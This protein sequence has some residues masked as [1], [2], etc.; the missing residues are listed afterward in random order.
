MFQCKQ[1]TVADNR[2]AMKI[3]TDGMLL[4]AWA[5]VH[6]NETTILDIGTGSGIIALMMAQRSIAE[7]IDGLEIDPDAYE[8][9]VE[10]F[11]N[12]KWNDR[13]F[14]YHAPFITFVEEIDQTYDLIVSNPPF[15]EEQYKTS[16][17]QRDLA[18]FQDA[19]PLSQLFEGVAKL[20]NL[21]GSFSMILPYRN[22]EEAIIIARNNKLYPSKICHVRGNSNS[23]FVRSLFSFTKKENKKPVE[24]ELIIEKERHQYTEAYQE[25][26]KEFYLKF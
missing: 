10:N 24:E 8:Q 7:M 1:F 26:T 25:L 20:L 22:R 17:V 12:S 18:R 11:E 3:G 9:A 19:L 21:E 4:G 16:S 2:C 23:N 15:Y 13:L 5:P 6:N 14:C